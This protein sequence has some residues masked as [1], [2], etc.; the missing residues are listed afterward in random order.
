M[1]E[2][3][4]LAGVEAARLVKSGSIVGL[5][6]GSTVK[7]SIEELGRRVSE[8]GL[9]IRAVPTSMGT[10]IVAVKNGIPLTSFDEVGRLDIAIDGADQVSGSCDLIKGGGAALFREKVVAANSREFVVVVDGSKLSSHLDLPVPVELLPFA[11]GVVAEHL[12]GLGCERAQLREC[13]GKSGPILTDNSNIILDASFGAIEW[14]EKLEEELN[15]IVGVVE[16][17][18]F[19]GLRPKV[20]VGRKGRVEVLE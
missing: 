18:I 17:G 16:N 7:Y 15:S 11:C 5:G 9:E 10:A 4:R 19:C 3:R 1:E 12:A 14:P 6:T 13:P 8:E 2:E 20:L